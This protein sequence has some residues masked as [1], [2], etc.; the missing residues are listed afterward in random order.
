M[1]KVEL[2][3]QEFSLNDFQVELT[4]EIHVIQGKYKEQLSDL[5][6]AEEELSPIQ[7]QL[8]EKERLIKALPLLFNQQKKFGEQIESV[9]INIERMRRDANLKL[10]EIQPQKELDYARTLSTQMLFTL[11]SGKIKDAERLSEQIVHIMKH[12]VSSV[13]QI[14]EL[15]GS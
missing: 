7:E 11:K 3:S 5:I 10:V 14:I 8:E 9:L 15:R 13:K 1:A 6:D 2:L 12:S 4:M